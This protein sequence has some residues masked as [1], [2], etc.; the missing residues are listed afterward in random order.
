MGTYADY[1]FEMLLVVLRE[2][3]EPTP[4]FDQVYADHEAAKD[5]GYEWHPHWRLEAEWAELAEAEADR[6]PF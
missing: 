4:I 5:A 2:P 1:L 6:G 3:E